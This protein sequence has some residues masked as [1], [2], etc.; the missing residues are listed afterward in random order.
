M[1]ENNIYYISTPAI[2][3]IIQDID[4]VDVLIADGRYLPKIFQHLQ[5]VKWIHITWAGM[6]VYI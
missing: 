4:S 2:E 3:K 6:F 1:K 5:K